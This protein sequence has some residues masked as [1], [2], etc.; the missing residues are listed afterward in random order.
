MTSPAV[1]A[2]P[3]APTTPVAAP[4]APVVAPNATPAV[5]PVTPS[6]PV[7]ATTDQPTG[8]NAMIEKISRDRELPPTVAQADPTVPVSAVPV[9]DG[10]VPAEQAAPV[11]QEGIV[12]DDGDV[13]LKF[14]RNPDGTF[15]SRIDPTQK[16]DIVMKDPE[17]GEARTYTKSVPELLRMARDGVW[18][19]KVKD[20][21][22][23]YRENVPQ[24]EQAHTAIA[25]EVQTLRE[26]LQAQMALN[27]ELLTAPDDIVIQRRE[28]F[29][30]QQSPEQRL[31][32]MEAELAQRQQMFEQSR[33]EQ[34]RAQQ[35]SG[36][37]QTRLA[38]VLA[39]AEAA[40]G[41]DEFAKRLVAGQVA[42]ATTPLLQNGQLPPQ[43]WPDVEA[44]LRGPF[45][46]WLQQAVQ[47]Q[48][49]R[50]V[51]SNAVR[52]MQLEAQRA[53]NATGQVIR[54]VGAVP[55]TVQTPATPPKNM[56]DA[57]SRIINK[58]LAGV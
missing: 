38:P 16:F 56:N 24:W 22:Q 28:E 37:I 48:Q 2:S 19:Q 29:A 14:E 53:V 23:Y 7:A 21:V 26:S 13:A 8:L 3:V 49:A 6:A 58:P 11:D 52:Q 47:S 4:V 41:G 43:R 27:R 55:G 32:R 40:L 57:I 25:S 50:T 51:D 34:E 18:G 42:L 20:E 44:Y 15:K 45:Q 35:A 9:S 46:Q 36:F 54:P 1:A 17:T 12:V 30:Y 33:Q 5:T 39:E 10:T 31:A